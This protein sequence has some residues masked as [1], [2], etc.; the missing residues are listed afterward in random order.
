MLQKLTQFNLWANDIISGYILK[1]EDKID[2]P[3]NSSFASIRKTLYHMWDAQVIWQTRIKG[4]PITTWP[5]KEFN[6]SIEEACTQF[7]ESSVEFISLVEK[8]KSDLLI[9]YH[10][11]DGKEFKSTLEDIII[12]VVNHGTYHRGQIITLLRQCGFTDVGSTDF[13]RF[14]RQ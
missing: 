8:E 5:S 3:V 2:L 1:A 4:N 12:H 11:L 7:R 6:G 13:I 9:T 14:T 10:T